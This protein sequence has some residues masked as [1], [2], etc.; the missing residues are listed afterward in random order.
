MVKD[1]DS[2]PKDKNKDSAKEEFKKVLDKMI[3]KGKIIIMEGGSVQTLTVS[4]SHYPHKL[5]PQGSYTLTP[6][7]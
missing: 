3:K 4:M 5:L 1:S 7:T 6:F 2:E